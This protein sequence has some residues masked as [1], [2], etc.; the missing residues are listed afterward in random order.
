[1]LLT[2]L[3]PDRIIPSSTQRKTL[4]HQ[5]TS[6]MPWEIHPWGRPPGQPRSTAEELGIRTMEIIKR[7]TWWDGWRGRSTAC[8]HERTSNLREPVQ[9]H[10]LQLL[11]KCLCSW[12]GPRKPRH[13]EHAA[14]VSGPKEPAMK[15]PVRH[16]LNH[17]C[18]FSS[19]D[20]YVRRLSAVRRN[21]Q[22][23]C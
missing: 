1:M 6:H 23:S 20:S 17:V 2:S 15:E 8:C 21:V 7:K 13:T 14:K 9:H 5:G 11:V 12:S 19:G 22:G 16:S 10:L 18:S 4:S 3:F